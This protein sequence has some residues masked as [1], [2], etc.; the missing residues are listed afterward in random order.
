VLG[1][2]AARQCLEHEMEFVM[3]QHHIDLNKR[4][5]GLLSDFMTWSGVVLGVNR[6]GMAKSK[7]GILVMA[8]FERTAEI[9]FDAAI[10]NRRDNLVGVSEAVITGQPVPLGTGGSFDLLQLPEQIEHQRMPWLHTASF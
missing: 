8:S 1:I 3:E 4:H 5:L 2:E 10:H 6:H 9:L 7:Q